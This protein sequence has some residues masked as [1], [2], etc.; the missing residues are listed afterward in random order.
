MVGGRAVEGVALNTPISSPYYRRLQAVSCTP[1]KAIFY[2]SFSGLRIG[3]GGIADSNGPIAL[4][5]VGRWTGIEE[6]CNDNWYRKDRVL[7]EHYILQYKLYIKHFTIKFLTLV[8]VPPPTALTAFQ[9]AVPKVMSLQ[10]L[11]GKRVFDLELI[12]FP[13]DGSRQRV[14][15]RHQQIYT[16][17]HDVISHTHI[18]NRAPVSTV[19]HGPK[20][21]LKLKK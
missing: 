7:S 6:W 9:N 13:E 18:H 15:P 17:L 5:K 2:S 4:P 21:K 11:Y 12:F 10:F 14:P 3:C 19:Y 16:N 8:L 20:K 1:S